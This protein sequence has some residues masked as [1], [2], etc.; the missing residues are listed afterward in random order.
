M[1]VPRQIYLQR[2]LI[3]F[4]INILYIFCSR[5]V[6]IHIVFWDLL[7]PTKYNF[8]IY[9]ILFMGIGVIYFRLLINISMFL[10]YSVLRLDRT[11]LSP[12][13]LYVLDQD[14]LEI[15]TKPLGPSRTSGTS[16]YSKFSFINISINWEYYK[17]YFSTTTT[18]PTGFRYMGYGLAICGTLAACVTYWCIYTRVQ[19]QQAVIQAVIQADQTKQQTYRTAREADVAAVDT[20]L[21]CK[22]EYYRHHP[23]DKP[24][25]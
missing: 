16:T 15:P 6:F 5:G 1:C 4:C 11:L 9:L 25:I 2:L 20:G 7:L 8:L 18:N 14:D 3:I 13:I 12:S 21:I 10:V 24:T 19:A 22:E 17:Q 23:Q